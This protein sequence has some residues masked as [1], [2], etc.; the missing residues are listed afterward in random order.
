MSI[1]LY[2]LIATA[3]LSMLCFQND[4]LRDRFM[5]NPYRIHEQR[6]WYRFISSGFIHAD[7]MHLL[8]NMFVLYMFGNVVEQYFSNVFEERGGFDF[9]LL[10]FGGMAVSTIRTYHKHKFDPGYRALGASGAVSAVVFSYIVFNPLEK[11]CL[12]GI[13]CLPGIIFGVGYLI[14]CYYAGKKGI[15]YVNHDAHLW[16]ALFGFFFTIMLKPYLAIYFLKQLP[17]LQHAF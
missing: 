15:G 12:Y 1:T 16:G 7:W 6:Q 2:L 8:V 3:I 4:E 11:L 13:L 14:Y 10:Y 5:F 9:L 17:F